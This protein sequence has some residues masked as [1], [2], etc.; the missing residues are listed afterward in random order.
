MTC[1]IKDLNIILCKLLTTMDKSNLVEGMNFNGDYMSFCD[2]FVYG[3]QHCMMY[4]QFPLCGG[5]CAK[6]MFGVVHTNLC[7]P[8][9]TSHG[10]AK[11]FLTFIVDFSWKTFLYTMKIEFGMLDKLKVLKIF[12]R[13][14]DWKGDQGDQM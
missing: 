11:Y 5:P 2:G 12:G 13:K 1:D 8:M 9:A 14:L 3:K 6:E 10:G 4:F 7:D